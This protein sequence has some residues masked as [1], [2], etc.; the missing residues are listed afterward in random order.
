LLL[1]PL[2]WLWVLLVLLFGLTK[3]SQPF[4]LPFSV[5]WPLPFDEFFDAGLKVNIL[6]PSKL[7]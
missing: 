4:P 5:L 3:P 1:L 7:P 2:V 6:T